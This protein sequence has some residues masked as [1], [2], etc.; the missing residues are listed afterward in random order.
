M[1]ASQHRSS[2]HILQLCSLQR[3]SEMHV[4]KFLMEAS[5]VECVYC[6]LCENHFL[7]LCQIQYSMHMHTL[8]ILHFYRQPFRSSDVLLLTSTSK[9]AG[10]HD[11]V[12]LLI[13]V[14]S[15]ERD[16]TS[17]DQQTVQAL[18]NMTPKDSG[19]TLLLE[20]KRSSH[21]CCTVCTL[22]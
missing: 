7:R 14:E 12:Q 16:P 19:G 8:M 5:S 22:P 10:R 18:V 1:E 6:Q 17:R 20:W 13:L 2:D 21:D 3:Q 15:V 4:A 9:G 11:A